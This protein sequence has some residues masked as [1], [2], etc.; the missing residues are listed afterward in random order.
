MTVFTGILYT[1][2][3]FGLGSCALGGS[4]CGCVLHCVMVIMCKSAV[5]IVKDCC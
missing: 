2:P 1:G 3:F 4:S 5:N